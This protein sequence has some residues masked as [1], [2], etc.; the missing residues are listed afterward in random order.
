L[1]PAISAAAVGVASGLQSKLRA[2]LQ[3]KMGQSEIFTN[4]PPNNLSEMHAVGFR[5][6]AHEC[7]LKAFYCEEMKFSCDP[8]LNAILANAPCPK[9]RSGIVI[10]ITGVEYPF[11]SDAKLKSIESLAHGTEP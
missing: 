2:V 3:L 6:R 9:G 4:L 7:S 10:K 1:I 8:S 5:S 11:D